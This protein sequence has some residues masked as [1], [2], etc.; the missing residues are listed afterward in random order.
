VLFCDSCCLIACCFRFQ[1]MIP[2][3]RRMLYGI[4]TKNRYGLGKP[5]SSPRKTK[6]AIQ[7]TTADLIIKERSSGPLVFLILKYVPMTPPARPK[8]PPAMPPIHP[9][10]TPMFISSSFSK[11]LIYQYYSPPDVTGLQDR[12]RTKQKRGAQGSPSSCSPYFFFT[13]VCPFGSS[14]SNCSG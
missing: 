14:F 12:L 4:H 5:R 10:M 8:M 9:H 7:H 13:N 11:F 3:G 1:K 6:I 2:R